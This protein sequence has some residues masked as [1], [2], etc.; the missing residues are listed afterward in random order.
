MVHTSR[1]R[2]RCDKV[3]CGAATAAVALRKP[4][5]RRCDIFASKVVDMECL[6]SLPLRVLNST[7]V[8]PGG[9]GTH[10]ASQFGL[11]VILVSQVLLA[12]LVGTRTVRTEGEQ[13][14]PSVLQERRTVPMR[15]PCLSSH[16]DLVA[17][18]RGSL[19]YLLGRHGISGMG[20]VMH[21]NP[22]SADCA[23]GPEM[24][25]EQAPP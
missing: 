7:R 19:S 22:E 15:M 18:Q 20:G 6:L 13:S 25:M 10:R 17:P 3:E 12:S 1:S 14:S 9:G 2:S 24:R 5:Q 4:S 23:W 8:L 21:A 11:Q 16:V